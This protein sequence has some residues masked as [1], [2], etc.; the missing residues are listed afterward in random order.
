NPNHR[1]P[2]APRIPPETPSLQRHGGLQAHQRAVRPAHWD[3]R[4]V[5]LVKNA[6]SRRETRATTPDILAANHLPGF[7]RQTAA[8][9][10]SGQLVQ[11]FHRVFHTIV[12]INH[13]GTPEPR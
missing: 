9:G 3:P 1:P 4:V 2:G 6:G 7:R 8:P 13:D 5:L 12:E 11:H 10:S